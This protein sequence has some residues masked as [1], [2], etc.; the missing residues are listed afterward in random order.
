MKFQELKKSLT[1]IRQAYFVRGSDAF[2]RQKAVDM[3]VNH[4]LKYKELNLSTFNDENTDISGIVSACQSIPMMDEHR[5]VVLRDIA[6]KKADEV[7]PIVNYLKKP[8]PSTVL[9]LVDSVGNS[10]LKKIE[11]LCE[12]V[13]CSPLDMSMLSKLV[14]NQLSTFGVK[15]NNDALANL[16]NF[17][18]NDY[19]RINN[20]VIKLGNLLGSGG[21]VTSEIVEQNVHRE[22]EFAVFELS[23]AVGAKN[24]ARAMQIVE[25]LLLRK[26][27]PQMLLIMIVNSFRRMFFAISSKDSNAVVAQKLGIKEYAVKIARESGAKFSPAQLKKILDLGAMLDFQIKTGEMDDKNALFYFITNI[28]AL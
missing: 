10:A 14:V 19:T 22:I 4:S 6:V 26:E 25:Q 7:A 8:L 27:S 21:L 2:L 3:I 20:E 16:V 24:G 1:T 9:I 13:D 23:N 12:V 15:I 17:C 11:P 18:G 5:V 28:S